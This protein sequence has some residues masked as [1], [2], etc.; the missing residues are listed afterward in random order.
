MNRALIVAAWLLG[1]AAIAWSC[2]SRQGA[3]HALTPCGPEAT[4]CVV[5]E[6]EAGRPTTGESA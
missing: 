1:L 4:D 5:A 3:T 2:S 6:V